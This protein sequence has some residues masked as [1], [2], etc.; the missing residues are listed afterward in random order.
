MDDKSYINNQISSLSD[1]EREILRTVGKMHIS[2]NKNVKEETIKKKLPDK[3]LKGFN[4]ALSNLLKSGLL[5]RYRA[6]NY[7]VSK[8]GRI[9]AN[10]IMKSKREKAYE[11]LKILMYTI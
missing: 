6:H 8:K 9:I 7:G 10:E 11:G 5:V 2:V 1:T 3:Y 4:K